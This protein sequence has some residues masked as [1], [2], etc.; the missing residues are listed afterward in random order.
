M[1][2]RIKQARSKPFSID[3]RFICNPLFFIALIILLVNDHYFKLIYGNWWTGKISDFTG[4]IVLPLVLCYFSRKI[5]T[6]LIFSGLLFVFWKSHI[7]QEVIDFYNAFAIIQISRVVDYTDLIA[8]FS[9]PFVYW[10][11]RKLTKISQWKFNFGPKVSLVILLPVV[12]VFIATAPP[13]YLRYTYSNGNLKCYKCNA[14]IKM[15]ETEILQLMSEMDLNIQIDSQLTYGLSEH[16]N[17]YM[18][19]SLSPEKEIIYY[20]IDQ[21]TIDQDT[22]SDIQFSFQHLSEDKTKIWVGGMN[23]SENFD[24]TNADRKVRR[25]YRK[26]LKKHLFK[27]LK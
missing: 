24:Y 8:L 10:Y 9:L 13:Y 26:I 4:M 21:L 11:A 6:N 14:T 16:E 18:K 2:W 7:S 20:R 3:Q 17:T 22:L 23:V 25:Y 27:K 12:F 5:I 15:S 19:D 1:W